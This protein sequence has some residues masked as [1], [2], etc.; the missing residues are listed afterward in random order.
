MT[1]TKTVLGRVFTA[2]LVYGD[3]WECYTTTGHVSVRQHLNGNWSA[4]L[5]N[6]DDECVVEVLGLTETD[7][8]LALQSTLRKM[9]ELEVVG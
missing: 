8:I 4:A 2:S 7:A 3:T 1:E 9:A 6:E 5:H